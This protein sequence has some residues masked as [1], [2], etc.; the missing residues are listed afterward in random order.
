[1]ILY[2]NLYLNTVK[3]ITLEMLEQNNIKG[4]ILDVDNTLIDFNKRMPEGIKEWADNLKKCNIKMCIVSNSNHKEKVENTAKKIEVP[5][6]FFAKKPCTGG[7]KKASEIMN[8]ENSQIAVAGDQIF[9]DVIGANRA[10]M[11]SILVKPIDEKDIWITRFKRP[12]E[13][14]IIQK[15]LK[16]TNKGEKHVH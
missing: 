12:I 8:L 14:K 7:L 15:Y 4:L 13:N 9:T 6:I 5:Y 11:F 1:M 3:E 2:P 16:Q 10:K